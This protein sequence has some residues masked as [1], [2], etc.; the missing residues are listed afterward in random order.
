M[1]RTARGSYSSSS[2]GALP[3]GPNQQSGLDP[4]SSSIQLAVNMVIDQSGAIRRRPGIS[5]YEGAPETPI[6]PEGLDGLHVAINGKVYAAGGSGG[7]RRLYRVTPTTVI[8]LSG[9]TQTDLIGDGRPVWAETEAMV[10]VAARGQPQKILLATDESS[11]LGGNPP[12]GSHIIANNGRLLL[13]NVAGNLNRVN[14]SDFASGSATLGHETWLSAADNDAGEFVGSAR[15]DPVVALAENGSEVFMFGTTFVQLRVQAAEGEV[16]PPVSFRELGCSAP[17]SVT[18]IDGKFAWLDHR[19]RFVISD[20]REVEVISGTI[21]KTLD[22][23]EQV[24]DCFGYRVVLGPVDAVVWTFPADGRSFAYAN[25]GW[26]QWTGWNETSATFARLGV[27]CAAAHPITGQNLLGMADGRV[28]VLD[29][30]VHTD[31]GKTIPVRAFTGF[32]NRDTDAIKHCLSVRLVFRRG[33]VTTGPEPTAV[34][35][36]RDEEDEWSPGIEVG[37]GHP[38]DR[39]PVVVL[40]SLGTYRRRQWRIDF[41]GDSE[42]ALASASE[43]YELEEE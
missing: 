19:R 6:D 26:S 38:G 33:T 18:K 31:L 24:N 28:G 30:K 3:F 37:L 42:F 20:G 15:P 9:T 41:D 1:P 27:S 7:A 25:G 12:A 21:Q 10:V 32:L 17:Y 35:S 16:Y 29:H 39:S 11:R 43:E 34:L 22:E 40:R 36:W 4:L 8:A 2:S 5:R 13:N 23:I 14:Y